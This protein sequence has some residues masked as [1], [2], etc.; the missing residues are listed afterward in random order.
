MALTVHRAVLSWCITT[1]T[2]CSRAKATMHSLPP[3]V[4][5]ADNLLTETQ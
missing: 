5:K 1:M 4:P 2:L 3:N